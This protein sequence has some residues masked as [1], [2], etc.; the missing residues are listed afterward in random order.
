MREIYVAD[1][2]REAL[3]EAMTEDPTVLVLGEDVERSTIGTT[4]GLIEKFGPTRVRNTPISEN[5]VLSACV[6]AAAS[7]VRPVFD[8]M[9]SSFF[10]VC[11]DAIANHDYGSVSRTHQGN[12]SGD[13]LLLDGVSTAA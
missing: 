8:I 6:G 3:T 12:L 9:F 1:A 2:I 7:G 4:K 5:G 13:H 10:Y 11:L